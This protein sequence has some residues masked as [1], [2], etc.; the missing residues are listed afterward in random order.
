[1]K[2]LWVFL[3]EDCVNISHDLSQLCSTY[4]YAMLKLRGWL[5]AIPKNL[6]VNALVKLLMI[7]SF[8]QHCLLFF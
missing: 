7:S 2:I 8:Q 3:V 1:M 5:N 4:I 6:I